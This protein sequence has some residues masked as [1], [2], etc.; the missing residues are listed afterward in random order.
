MSLERNSAFCTN[1][2]AVSAHSMDPWPTTCST[3]THIPGIHV[4]VAVAGV[5]NEAMVGAR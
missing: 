3:H 1:A 2:C 5:F 4:D